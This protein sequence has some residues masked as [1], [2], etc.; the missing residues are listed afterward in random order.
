MAKTKTSAG[1]LIVFEGPDGVG[2]STLSA[3]LSEDLRSRGRRLK[4]MTFPGREPGSVGK[5]VYEV[6]HDPARFGVEQL[7]PVCL[8]ALHIA[9]HL[10]AIER[11]IVPLLEAG[12]DVVLD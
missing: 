1:R 3:A 7:A 10:D 6:H 12:T 4:L 11:R 8:Q 5:L 9:A 2:K